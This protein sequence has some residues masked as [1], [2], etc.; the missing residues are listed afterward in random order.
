[1]IPIDN[2]EK[3]RQRPL[4]GVAEW[5]GGENFVRDNGESQRV[6]LAYC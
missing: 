6:P 3:P 5:R 2:G 1:M 4:Y